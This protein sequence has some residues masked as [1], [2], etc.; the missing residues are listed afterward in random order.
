M[1]AFTITIAVSG[2]PN[3][4]EAEF[5]SHVLNVLKAMNESPAHLDFEH[6]FQASILFRRDTQ[7]Q[8]AANALAQS[9]ASEMA[10]RVP[11]VNRTDAQALQIKSFTVEKWYVEAA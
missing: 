11:L 7:S 8:F 6:R 3:Q 9:L 1:P 2:N 5:Q 4:T 10:N